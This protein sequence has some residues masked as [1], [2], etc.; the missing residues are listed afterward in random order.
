MWPFKEKRL[1]WRLTL[2]FDNSKSWYFLFNK[3]EDAERM[4]RNITKEVAQARREKRVV[5]TK[6]E[7][8]DE[9]LVFRPATVTFFGVEPV[10]VPC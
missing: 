10:S 8:G 6:I 2:V 9:A 5:L 1:A 3:R 7:K 4:L